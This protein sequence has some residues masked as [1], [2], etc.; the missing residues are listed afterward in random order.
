[1]MMILMMMI[2]LTL[3][4]SLRKK[5]LAQARLVGSGAHWSGVW[6]EENG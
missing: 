1:M 4:R 6:D 3:S 5:K 2:F